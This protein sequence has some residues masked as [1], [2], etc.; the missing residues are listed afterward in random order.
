MKLIWDKTSTPHNL[1]T[2]LRTLASSYPLIEGAGRKTTIR[3]NLESGLDGC[4]VDLTGDTAVISYSTAT[5]AGRALG[6]LMSGLAK[7]GSIYREATPCTTVGI[8]LDCSRNAVMTVD[9]LKVWLRRLCLLGYNM[10]MLYTEDTYELP[11][12]PYFGYQRGAYTAAEIR[13]IDDYAHALGIEI[14]PCIQTLGH[15]DKVLRHPTYR[16]CKDTNSVFMVGEKKTYALIEKMVAFWQKNCRTRRIHIGM[17]EAHDLGRGQYL[18]NIGYRSGF[19]LFNEHLGAVA[20]ICK[21]QGLKPMIWSDMYFRFGNKAQ[22]YYDRKTVIPQKVIDNIPATVGLVYWD[23]YHPDKGF[24]REW[25][26]RHRAMGK[27]PIMGSGIWTW[28]RYWYDHRETTK[29]ADPCIDAC[30]AEQ[31]REIF[32]TQWGDNGDYCDH[33][34]AFAGMVNCANRIY[35]SGKLSEKDNN[36]HFAAICGG[37]YSATILAS[38]LHGGINGFMPNMWDD[39]IY[40]THFRT[41]CKD[42]PQK[43]AQIALGFTALAKKIK[44]VI[45]VDNCGDL[46]YAHSTAQAFADRYDLAADLLRAYRSKNKRRMESIAKK[47]PIVQA[48]I[49]TMAEAFRAMWMRHNKPQG[50]ETIQS[51]FGTLNARYCELSHRISEYRTGLIKNI[52]ELD[53]ACPPTFESI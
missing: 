6:V 34:S 40:E 35:T 30:R 27:E 24:Y 8:M 51:R 49:S 13:A 10:V 32:F 52:A 21:K 37:S 1:H 47:I 36:A 50:I 19:D 31:L 16:A 3:F 15:L 18:D 45:Q 46:H 23:Y 39:P 20:A 22:N 29:T 9:Q 12:E 38:D 44:R 11:G 5:Q 7:T 14:I 43:M 25:I 53:D 48:S 4:R 17:D 2:M 41:F 33:D 28:D 26:R 42:D